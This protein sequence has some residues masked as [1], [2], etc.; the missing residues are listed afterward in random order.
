MDA[1]A[2]QS[3][4]HIARPLYHPMAEAIALEGMRLVKEYLAARHGQPVRT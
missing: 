3:G 2:H 1:L 4:S